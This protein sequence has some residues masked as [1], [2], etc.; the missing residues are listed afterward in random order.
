M[1]T[2]TLNLCL[3][4]LGEF[5]EIDPEIPIQTAAMLL[6]VAM[7]PGVT[8][9]ELGERLGISQA[10]CSRNVAALSK[11]HRLDKPGY[12]LVYAV[13]DPAERR[14]KIVRLTPQG[15]QFMAQL[16][17]RVGIYTAAQVRDGV[18]NKLQSLI[19]A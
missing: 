13:E 16:L 3:S 10:S 15:E 6:V 9:K 18:R 12:D 19:E 4:I 8:M 7:T 14:R 11:V 2:E 17:E 1:K 5:R